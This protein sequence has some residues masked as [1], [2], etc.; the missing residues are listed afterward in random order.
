ME[1]LKNVTEQG[2]NLI[3]LGNALS[4]ITEPF[5]IIAS[6]YDDELTEGFRYLDTPHNR[7]QVLYLALNIDNEFYLTTSPN[8][9]QA[10]IPVTNIYDYE[11][12]RQGELRD[13]MN[14]VSQTYA[15]ELKH[16]VFNHT[17]KYIAAMLKGC[18][19][20]VVLV[21]APEQFWV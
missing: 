21:I 18:V 1:L 17:H 14:R 5:N 11:F 8:E 13:A 19:E 20:N 3:A 15:R 4:R 7:Y 6:L 10:Y 2:H 16:F 9:A 12:E